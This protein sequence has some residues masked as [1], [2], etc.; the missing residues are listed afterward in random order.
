M[1][2]LLNTALDASYMDTDFALSALWH[3]FILLLLLFLFICNYQILRLLEISVPISVI[4]LWCVNEALRTKTK[5]NTEQNQKPKQTVAEIKRLSISYLVCQ[6][7]PGDLVSEITGRVC[8]VCEV[9]FNCLPW[10]W[11][12]FFS[13]FYLFHYVR[14]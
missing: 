9:F 1:T 7:W 6:I 2:F 13:I 10:I 8:E 3:R 11:Q 14:V 5:T 4:V 12:T